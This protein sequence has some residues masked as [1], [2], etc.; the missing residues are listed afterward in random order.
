MVC[1]AIMAVNSNPALAAPPEGKGKKDQCSCVNV[2]DSSEP[3]QFVGLLLGSFPMG[4]P[5]IEVFIPSSN[6]RIAIDAASGSVRSWP[7]YGWVYTTSDCTGALY[8][9]A[10][11]LYMGVVYRSNHDWLPFTYYMIEPQPIME[12]LTVYSQIESFGC[13]DL[14]WGGE[15]LGAGRITGIPESEIPFTEPLALPLQYEAQ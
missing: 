4:T 12:R 10:D 6:R 7:Y 2:Y 11:Q 13:T 8:T 5:L 15:I 1:F 14:S 3:R 9:Q